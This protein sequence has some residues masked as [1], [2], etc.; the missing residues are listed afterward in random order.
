MCISF[1][2][3]WC[4]RLSTQRRYGSKKYRY[5]LHSPFE[6]L[7]NRYL[8]GYDRNCPHRP[9]HRIARANRKQLNSIFG[10]DN[11]VA[12]CCGCFSKNLASD[13]IGSREDVLKDNVIRY[14]VPIDLLRRH[15]EIIQEILPY[16][17]QP[18]L[19]KLLLIKC[20]V[21]ADGEV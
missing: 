13:K 20:Y 6:H 12:A 16:L 15:S 1:P 9:H 17:F 21:V 8:P 4:A 10:S 11:C 7:Q 5:R 19:N 3:S 14:H 2:C 18:F